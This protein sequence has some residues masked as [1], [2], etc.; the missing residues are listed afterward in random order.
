M[1]AVLVIARPK[2]VEKFKAALMASSGQWLRDHATFTFMSSYDEAL[3]L[4]EGQPGF[5]ALLLAASLDGMNS[6]AARTGEL[7]T[8]AENIK[9]PIRVAASPD[10]SLNMQLRMSGCNHET[11]KGLGALFFMDTLRLL[12]T[13]LKG[14]VPE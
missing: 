4:I 6:K 10:L 7:A 12:E 2:L 8:G 5:D 1:K 3:R 13:L 11:A 9:I 14:D